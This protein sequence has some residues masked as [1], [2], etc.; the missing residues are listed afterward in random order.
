VVFAI[1]ALRNFK[2]QGT[3]VLV[4]SMFF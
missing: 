4:W 3:V 1:D 2:H